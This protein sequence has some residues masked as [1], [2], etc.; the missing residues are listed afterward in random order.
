[1][2][3]KFNRLQ[4]K[5]IVGLSD[6]VLARLMDHDYPG[7]V[8]ELE[9]IIEQAFVLCRGGMI[10]LHHLPPELRPTAGHSAGELASPTTL[11]SMERL[12]IAEALRR[13]RGNRKRAARDLGIDASTLY[14]KLKSLKIEPPPTDGRSRAR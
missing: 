10:E 6:E 2:V 7:N 13:H 3:A 1:L 5:D 12:L 8:R 9:N 11:E 4:G 14:R